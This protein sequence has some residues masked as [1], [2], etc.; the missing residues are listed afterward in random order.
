VPG[1]RAE[2]WKAAVPLASVPVP[3]VVDPS[4]NVTVPVG[5][6]DDALTVAVRVIA[7]PIND[8]F[9]EDV[10][11][12]LLADLLA[13]FVGGGVVFDPPPPQAA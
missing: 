6:P 12:V 9:A 4:R 10:T 11:A 13:T 3:S 7:C 1:V 8:G 5:A 2:A